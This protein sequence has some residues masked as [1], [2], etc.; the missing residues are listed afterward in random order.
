[1][2]KNRR[3]DWLHKRGHVLEGLGRREEAIADYRLAL[4][5]APGAKKYQEELKRLGVEP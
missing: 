3:V 5:L 4:R 2:D 1:L